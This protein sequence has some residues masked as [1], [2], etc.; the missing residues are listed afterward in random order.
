MLAFQLLKE[1]L[2]QENQ[3]EQTNMILKKW[4]T[5]GDTY[6]FTWIAYKNITFF[7]SYD[8]EFNNKLALTDWHNSKRNVLESSLNKKLLELQSLCI[9][10]PFLFRLDI[11]MTM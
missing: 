9:V 4:L 8:S 5:G 11:F 2:G 1:K 7:N 10:I 3:F 6:N